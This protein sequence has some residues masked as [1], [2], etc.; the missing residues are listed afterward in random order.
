[1]SGGSGTVLETEVGSDG[2]ITLTLRELGVPPGTYTLS[3]NIMEEMSVSC[4]GPRECITSPMV[5]LHDL[6]IEIVAAGN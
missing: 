2:T 3:A 5:T 6:P 4:E 1:V